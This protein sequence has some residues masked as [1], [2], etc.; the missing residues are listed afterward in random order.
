[1]LAVQGLGNCMV[2]A[3]VGIRPALRVSI[4]A[5]VCNSRTTTHTHHCCAP[6]DVQCWL[7]QSAAASRLGQRR[8]PGQ[9]HH[10]RSGAATDG[11]HRLSSTWTRITGLCLARRLQ[12]CLGVLD[13]WPGCCS[14]HG[15]M[16]CR[17][18]RVLTGPAVAVLSQCL[19]RRGGTTCACPAADGRHGSCS[20]PG[21]QIACWTPFAI[22]CCSSLWLLGAVATRFSVT[23]CC[24]ATLP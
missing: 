23:L 5:A 22:A 2:Q 10:G 12:R 1:V 14:Q 21:T 17:S 11:R 9:H 20:A 16:L 6:Q 15:E 24:V 8:V 13:S 3:G 19:F 18:Y 4:L 7:L